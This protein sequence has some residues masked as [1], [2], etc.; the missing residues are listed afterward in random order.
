MS[1]VPFPAIPP[2]ARSYNP[3]TY[4]QTEFV[5]QNG[6]TSI[7]R[8]GNKRVN[9]SLKLE[10]RYISAADATEIIQNYESV[11]S[12]WDYVT[13]NSNNATIGIPSNSG[14]QNYITENGSGLKWRYAK[15][16]EIS[17]DASGP[18]GCGRGA[19]NVSCE[20]TAFFDGD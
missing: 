15:P 6:S 7:I 3:G 20:F 17:A 10:F 13:F 12:D 19:C 11:N 18:T 9:A 14:L 1:A 16:P 8:F 4:P 5:S 2:Y